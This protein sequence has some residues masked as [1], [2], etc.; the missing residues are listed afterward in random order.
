MWKKAEKANPDV[1]PGFVWLL[2]S[3]KVKY[4][5]SRGLKCFKMVKKRFAS[6][7]NVLIFCGLVE[8]TESSCMK[9]PVGR[10]NHKNPN[11]QNKFFC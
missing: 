8:N 4:C 1:R 7:I 10:V 6:L 2:T 3:S 5:L 11:E 9:V